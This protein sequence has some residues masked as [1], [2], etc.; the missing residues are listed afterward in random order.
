ML[1]LA[2]LTAAGLKAYGFGVDPVARTGIF[3]AP[4]FQFLVILFEVGLGAWLLSGKQHLC[5]WLAVLV[6]F[7]AF[8]GISSYQGVIGQASC[9]CLGSKVSVNPWIM[10]GIDLIAVA[11]LLIARPDFKPLWENRVRIVRTT[12]AVVGAYL[13]L[14]GVLVGF[15]HV[16]YG[17][18]DAALAHLRNERISVNPSLIDMGEDVPG[19]TRE[20]A[21]ELTNHTDQP[22]RLIGGT[23]DCSCTVLA[24]LPVT[25]PPGEARSITVTVKLPNSKGAFNRKAALRIDDQGFNTVGFRLTGR[26]D[27]GSK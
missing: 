15:A 21:V 14:M 20:A 18:V 2:L 11:A 16:A 26:I 12:A 7:V 6:T 13:L 22:I 10:F 4:A 24:D 3:S 25:I 5:A 23:S 27:V 17:S 19:E 9:G 1:G 8:A